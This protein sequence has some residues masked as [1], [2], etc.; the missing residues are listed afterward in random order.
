MI[1]PR[2]TRDIQEVERAERGGRVERELDGEGAQEN[3]ETHCNA[4]PKN[5]TIQTTDTRATQAIDS[6]SEREG[7]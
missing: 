3:P 2:A 7:V 4:E 1:L 5:V 6:T